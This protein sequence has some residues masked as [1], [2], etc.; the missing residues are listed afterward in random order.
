MALMQ[1][2]AAVKCLRR[3]GTEVDEC[4]LHEEEEEVPVGPV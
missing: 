2:D 1:S 4:Q 3:N